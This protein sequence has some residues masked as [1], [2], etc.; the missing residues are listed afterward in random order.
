MKAELESLMRAMA[1]RMDAGDALDSEAAMDIAEQHRKHI[2]RWFYPCAP[3][4]HAKVAELYTGDDRFRSTF[5]AH[6]EGLAAYFA[7]AVKANS[8]R[9]D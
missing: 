8:A 1:E 5:D 9:S 4:M 7:G 3:R 2:D 6:G